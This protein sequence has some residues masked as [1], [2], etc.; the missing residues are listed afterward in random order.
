MASS[1]VGDF[2]VVLFLLSLGAMDVGLVA[3]LARPFIFIA[4]VIC[5]VSSIFG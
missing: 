4:M 3:Y 1:A 5:R 2:F